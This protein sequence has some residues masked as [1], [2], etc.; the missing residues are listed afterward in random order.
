MGAPHGCRSFGAHRRA[1]KTME[2]RG[3]GTGTGGHRLTRGG[4]FSGGSP[5]A[6]FARMD[7]PDLQSGHARGYRLAVSRHAVRVQA[8]P[9]RGRTTDF[10][11]AEAGWLRLRR[12]SPLH[13]ATP[14]IPVS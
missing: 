14:E 7:G 10:L 5:P 12:G 2:R 11:T 8:V 6:Y 1:G 4:P 9:G 13:R 3:A